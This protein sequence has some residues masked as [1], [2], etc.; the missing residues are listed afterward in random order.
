MEI[1]CP[2]YL[3]F[4]YCFNVGGGR[5]SALVACNT[6]RFQALQMDREKMALGSG[7]PASAQPSPGCFPLKFFQHFEDRGGCD[8]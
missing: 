8:E 1:V 4:D 3:L 6:V 5:Y 2:L 7:F